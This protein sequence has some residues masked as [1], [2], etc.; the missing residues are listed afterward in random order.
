MRTKPV[1]HRGDAAA[2]HPADPATAARPAPAVP[3][4]R[5]GGTDQADQL[6]SRLAAR[7]RASF[8]KLVERNRNCFRLPDRHD[9]APHPARL[10]GICGWAAALGLLG[11]PVAGRS[12][13]AIITDNAP[14]WFEPTVVLVG[15]L[16]I[17]MTAAT[18][19]A[20]HRRRLPWLL[21]TA[22]T[23]LLAANLS[24]TL[25]L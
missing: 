17:V 25:T 22:A 14:A 15:V 4:P 8:A 23:A 7:L 18:F 1:T 11:L 9:P 16:G 24:I 20:I 2:S 6:G 10:V 5:D 21:L 19:A 13:V 3:R 12:S